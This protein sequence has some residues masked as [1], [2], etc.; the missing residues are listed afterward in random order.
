MD[1]TQIQLPPSNVDPLEEALIFERRTQVLAALKTLPVEQRIVIELAYYQ[2]LSQS[3]IVAQTG[4]PLGTVKTRIR[5]GLNKLR[6][7]L[8]AWNG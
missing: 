4:L 6:V 3:E 1:T 7:A 5:L 2:G 8:G